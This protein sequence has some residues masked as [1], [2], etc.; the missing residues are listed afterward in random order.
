MNSFMNEIETFFQ[1]SSSDETWFLDDHIKLPNR[2]MNYGDGLFETMV[3]IKGEIRFLEKHVDRI[4][5]GMKVLGLDSYS[6]NP[7][8][9]VSLLSEKCQ[10]KVRRIRWSVF[11]AGGGK[12]TPEISEVHQTLQIS[13]FSPAAILKVKVG[14]SRQ[15][16]LFPTPWSGFKSLNALP[17]VLANQERKNRGLDEIVLLDYRGFV[18]EASASN[19]FWIRDEVIYTPALS[20][21]CINGVSRQMILEH[22]SIKNI[23][24]SEGEF[25]VSELQNAEQVFVSNCTGISYLESFEGTKF[26]TEPLSVLKEIFE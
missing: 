19:I 15:I 3:W 24:F 7:E 22:L 8:E 26:T 18:S 13:D 10:T 16:K 11:R 21:S 9:L 17:Y 12:Y 23:P 5:S 14:V 6:I 20:C 2:A 4:L 1:K 25:P